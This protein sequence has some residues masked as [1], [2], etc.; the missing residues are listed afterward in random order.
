M[1]RENKFLRDS[2]LVL[3]SQ[4]QEA[5]T[6]NSMLRTIVF[7]CSQLSTILV[8]LLR[9]PGY[10]LTLTFVQ[11]SGIHS[12]QLPLT[13]VQLDSV[14]RELQIFHRAADG[15][16]QP[17]ALCSSWCIELSG[18]VPG[19]HKEKRPCLARFTTDS[20][21]LQT[22][23]VKQVRLFHAQGQF[24]GASMSCPFTLVTRNCDQKTNGARIK[25]PKGCVFLTSLLLSI[26]LTE[27]HNQ[28][29]SHGSSYPIS[30]DSSATGRPAH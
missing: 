5:L 7:Q 15:S 11:K 13:D 3:Q 6:A 9:Q 25:R 8:Q 22:D 14:S 2:V 23:S 10:C 16:N 26:N 17:I 4:L 21:R 18:P 30:P 27:H 12:I 20:L 19:G 24:L 28:L 1:E 29:A